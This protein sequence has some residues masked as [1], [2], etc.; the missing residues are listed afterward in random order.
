M[1][2]DPA[3]QWSINLTAGGYEHRCQ[4][5]DDLKQIKRLGS[6]WRRIL[7]ATRLAPP[8]SAFEIGCG[9]ARNLAKLALNGFSVG[10][11]DLSRA[12]LAR[13]KQFIAEVESVSDVRLNIEL[14][15]DDFFNFQSEKRYDLVYHYGVV[16]HY[17]DP[18]RRA[19]FWRKALE[20]TVAGG[21]IASVVP[22]GQHL[23]RPMTRERELLGYRHELAE[24]DYSCSSHAEEL[25]RAGMVNI[26]A[27]PHSYFFFLSD[28]PNQAVRKVLYPTIFVIGNVLLPWLPLPSSV[29]EKLAHTL[30][31]VGQKPE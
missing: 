20:L 6:A 14:V 30:I 27:L 28:H 18:E 21:W 16:E 12:V 3:E 1:V 11:I 13:A 25:E 10:G 2:M 8:A 5:K 31:V 29:A 7:G 24:I 9:G 26:R 19:E 22:C 15:K 17:L 4:D 23:M